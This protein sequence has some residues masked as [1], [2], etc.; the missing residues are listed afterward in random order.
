MSTKQIQVI[1]DRQP[2]FIVPGLKKG[3]DLRDALGLQP[4]D[5]IFLEVAGDIDV[6][7]AAHD[8]ILVTGGEAFSVAPPGSH[9]VEDNPPL[10]HPIRCFLNDQM[11]SEAQALR[12]PK[13]KAAELKALDLNANQGSRLVADLDGLVDELIDD[14]FRIIVK[15][16]DK[17]IVIPPEERHE[18][19]EVT[20]RV[21]GKE[22]TLPAGDYRVSDL[23]K[24]LGISADYDLDYIKHGVFELLPDDSMFDLRHR[25]EF[26]SHVRT[27]SSS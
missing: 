18:P 10:R 20:V 27:G 25:E 11:L 7:V 23:K 13:V 24:L 8:F 9:L 1:V 16:N 5:N 15:P 4:E 14:A 21:D 26:V 17:F 2:K 22:V 19:H 6:H 12:H 3:A